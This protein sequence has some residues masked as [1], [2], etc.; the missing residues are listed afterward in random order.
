MLISNRAGKAITGRRSRSLRVPRPGFAP[1]IAAACATLAHPVDAQEF[2]IGLSSTAELTYTN[3][4]DF[5]VGGQ[6]QSAWVAELVGTM[7]VSAK[8]AKFSL[9]GSISATA[10]AD[11]SGFRSGVDIAPN[12]A[13]S[14]TYEA[15]DNY[16]FIDYHASIG[17]TYS[18][19]FGPQPANLA[20]ASA[21]RYTQ[22]A[23]GV[24]PYVR[25]KLPGDISYVIRDD[26]NWTNST[27]VGNSAFVPPDTYANALSVRVTSSPSHFRWE[28]QYDRDYYDSGVPGGTSTL[29][30]VRLVVP[31]RIDPTFELSGRV[32]YE[33][34]RFSNTS[35]ESNIYG[36]GVHWTPT[37]RTNIE[38]V[39][40]HRF[41]G[42][43]YS[44][45]AT[46]R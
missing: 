18:T 20:N 39:W 8:T 11:S 19:P 34:A 32:G 26:N 37:E 12:G 10:I 16:A 6:H 38:G 9:N 4:V 7:N 35:D 40:E 42:T 30:Q 5:S 25:G 22:Q 3:N 28:L 41:F 33:R 15:I 2:R 24:S 27:N 17:Q 43:G 31:F 13:F 45:S 23:Y 44:V 21:N 14:G 46:H 1:V 36:F 29:D